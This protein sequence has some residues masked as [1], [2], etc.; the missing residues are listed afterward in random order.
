M[1]WHIV[2]G[3]KGE[4]DS[5]ISCQ[6]L[7]WL[8]EWEGRLTDEVWPEKKDIFSRIDLLCDMDRSVSVHFGDL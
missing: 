1:K 8:A 7:A 6:M 5:E 2:K 3:H 4:N